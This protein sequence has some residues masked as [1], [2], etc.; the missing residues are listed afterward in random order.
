MEQ[1]NEQ[2]LISQSQDSMYYRLSLP[3]EVTIEYFKLL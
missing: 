3:Y 2:N 1:I